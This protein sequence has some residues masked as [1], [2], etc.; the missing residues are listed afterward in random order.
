MT[1][2]LESNHNAQDSLNTYRGYAGLPPL[3]GL[4]TMEGA[5]Q[6]GLTFAES[7]ARLSDSIGR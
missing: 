1:S 7:V 6:K 2:R 5:Q 3:V 4:E